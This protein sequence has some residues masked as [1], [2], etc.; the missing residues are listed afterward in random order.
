[1]RHFIITNRN[2]I[3]RNGLEEIEEQNKY[4][5]Q[6]LRFVLYDFN[7]KTVEILPDFPTASDE[8]ETINYSDL[9]NPS[10]AKGSAK[11]FGLLYEETILRRSNDTLFYIH[12]FNRG[13]NNLLEDIDELH[14]LFV[15]DKKCP[16]G[17][18]VAFSWSANENLGEF[19]DNRINASYSGAALA[20]GYHKLVKFFSQDLKK[21]KICN[22]N[23]HLL[24]HSIGCQVLA[25]M[26]NSVIES[27]LA[28]KQIF[29]EIILVAPD[30]NN[31][32]LEQGNSLYRIGDFGER[33]HIYFN[34]RDGCFKKL[35]NRNNEPYLG[36][37][38]PANP[39]NIRMNINFVDTSYIKDARE[40][41]EQQLADHF[42]YRKSSLVAKDIKKVIK[43]ISSESIE[44][45][46][47][48]NHKNTFRIIN[49]CFLF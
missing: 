38:G 17:R 14:R 46:E 33:I 2:I 4:L 41:N 48:L 5:S 27:H 37:T 35:K 31:N 21:G 15:N 3:Y 26:I 10:V 47:F 34:N 22:T 28:T 12:G 24:C 7:S 8:Y 30:I 32:A 13:F 36:L 40:K 16:I 11:W 6:N 23:I 45:R 9:I 18:I 29:K 25:G 42:Y 19:F 44:N 39:W 43:G 49:D 1:M 20:R